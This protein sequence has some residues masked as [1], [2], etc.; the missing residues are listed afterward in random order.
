[1]TAPTR[2]VEL[3]HAAGLAVHPWT[4]RNESQYLAA[5]YQGD[6]RAEYAAYAALGV[7][8]V[9]SDFPDTAL[10]ALGR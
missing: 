5:D 8:A 3:A 1:M 6:P 9:F 7:D 2:F 4:F 10:A